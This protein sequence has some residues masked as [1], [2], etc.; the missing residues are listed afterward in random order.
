M[1]GQ[2]LRFVSLGIMRKR[3]PKAFRDADFAVV[4]SGLFLLLQKL[5]KPQ[6]LLLAAILSFLALTLTARAAAPDVTGTWK[7]N[8]ER[9]GETREIVMKLKQNEGKVAGTIKGPDGQEL[10]I[11]N[12]KIEPDGKLTFV[13]EIDRDGNTMKINFEGKAAGETITGKT[14]FVNAQGE[15]REREWVARREAAKPASN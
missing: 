9:D 15:E 3:E 14:K 5:M 8:F 1:N 7:W 13:L 2:K 4:N 10:E 11:R 6:R 12:G